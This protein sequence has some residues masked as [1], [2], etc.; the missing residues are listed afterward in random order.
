MSFILKK[1][2][3]SDQ[4]E[5][6]FKNIC[7]LL[8]IF[9]FFEKINFENSTSK[10]QFIRKLRALK[11]LLTLAKFISLYKKFQATQQNLS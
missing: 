2:I 8:Y 10:L 11:K 1:I 7:F 5:N 6:F 4:Y 3:Y 9:E